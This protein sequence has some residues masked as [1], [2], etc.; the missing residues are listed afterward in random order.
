M[1]LHCRK[2]TSAKSYMKTIKN[3]VTS[4]MNLVVTHCSMGVSSWKE[5]IGVK[6]KYK[7]NLNKQLN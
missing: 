1:L 4:D 6:Q 2:K 5:L 3:L 7:T